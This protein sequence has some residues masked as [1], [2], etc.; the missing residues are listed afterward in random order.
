MSGGFK[1]PRPFFGPPTRLYL[2]LRYHSPVA[3]LAELDTPLGGE[4]GLAYSIDAEEGIIPLRASEPTPV[5]D[6]ARLYPL[7]AE[8]NALFLY[9]KET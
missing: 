7:G 3:L 4:Q 9:P 1:L 5:L 2:R 8:P 6:G